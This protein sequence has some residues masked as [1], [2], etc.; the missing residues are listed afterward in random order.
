MNGKQ[1]IYITLIVILAITSV[2]QIVCWA[3]NVS[4]HN[5]LF[6]FWATAI[7]YWC[8][9]IAIVYLTRAYNDQ[10]QSTLRSLI[11]PQD[12]K[13]PFWKHLVIIVCAPILFPIGGL[14]Y[15]L[16]AIFSKNKKYYATPSKPKDKPELTIEDGLNET[17][18]YK[19]S[20]A[21]GDA[22][23]TGNFNQFEALLA[24]NVEIILYKSR[25]IK[26]RSNVAE[27][28]KGWREKYVTTKKVLEFEV[29]YCGNY[30]R[31]CLKL[32]NMVALF[33]IVEGKIAMMLLSPRT[34]D[35]FVA[36]SGD[37]LLAL[38]MNLKY[39]EAHYTPIK[40]LSF[41]KGNRLPCLICGNHSENLEWHGFLINR[42]IHG[43]S[44]K[45]SVCPKCHRVV[46]LC[47]EVRFRYE[48]PHKDEY[49]IPEEKRHHVEL[50]LTGMMCFYAAEI[51][52]GTKYVAALPTDV[53]FEHESFMPNPLPE[54]GPA[55]AKQIAE[56]CNW[57]LL[58][59]M[60]NEN[61]ALFDEVMGAY[62]RAIEDGIYEAANNVGIWLYNYGNKQAE[63]VEY[64]KLAVQHGSPNA[65]HN[66]FEIFIGQEKVGEAIAFLDDIYARPDASLRCLWNYA[67]LLCLG[68]NYKG[69]TLKQDFE[70]AKSALQKII[71]RKGAPTSE[72]NINYIFDNAQTLLDMISD[73]N[74]YSL[75]GLEFHELLAN[76][77]TKETKVKNKSNIFESLDELSL[78][79]GDFLGL[80]L[81]SSDTDDI[82]DESEF[83]VYRSGDE[84][85]RDVLKHLITKQSPMAAWQIYLLK[86]S[87]TVMPVFWHGGYIRRDYIF[88][89]E[90]LKQIAELK[91]YDLSAIEKEDM[92]LPSVT[93]DKT[94]NDKYVAH[95]YC[96]FWNDWKGLVREHVEITITGNRVTEYK[97]AGA[98][99]LHPYDCGILF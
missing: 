56:D 71:D 43:Y 36:Y 28:W 63:G 80:R 64:L 88:S 11:A 5:P 40:D 54:F 8:A 69:S 35:S 75:K 2:A 15:G 38:P 95:V 14:V 68:D 25:S 49:T 31:A 78:P 74:E 45:I 90:S 82:G 93:V 24:D 47:P 3:A 37:D 16:D 77:T 91:K 13:L 73:S 19:A 79:Q 46:E 22:M 4:P 62:L 92:I 87:P 53:M 33:R 30:S 12:N 23:V 89:K 67:V 41:E 7:Y 81:A 72:E 18:Y 60:H 44:G 85:D 48:E 9:C 17:E 21:L 58:Q 55:S 10:K 70:K 99:I 20:K 6:S 94:S 59:D 32:K 57:F 26:G 42:G 1:K 39:A 66:Y 65:M 34:L 51:L 52:R 83:Y 27:Y 50:K 29:T 86:T 61:P 98:L 96:T 97:E 84:R 76:H